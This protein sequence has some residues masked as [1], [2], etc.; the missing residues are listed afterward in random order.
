MSKPAQP[1]LQIEMANY[2]AVMQSLDRWQLSILWRIAN[3]VDQP[4]YLL[5]AQPLVT[6]IAEPLVLDHS[7]HEPTVPLSTNAPRRFKI[8]TIR[9][10]DA[11]EQRM[12]Y[13]L[14]LPKSTQF[15]RVVGRF[16]YSLSPPDAE[17]EQNQNWRQIERWQQIVE[18]QPETVAPQP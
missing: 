6:T 8:V 11:L 12:E 7:A 2:R 18:S 15:L 14:A 17:W 10:H 9:S 16:G 1:P 13:A 5:L 3:L 4:L